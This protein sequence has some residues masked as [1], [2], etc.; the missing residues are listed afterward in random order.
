MKV[1]DFD[2][3]EYDSLVGI[4]YDTTYNGAY[5][6]AETEDG[7]YIYGYSRINCRKGDFVLVSVKNILRNGNV[8]FLVE[9]FSKFIFSNTLFC[10]YLKMN[11]KKGVE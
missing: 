2:V 9:S 1:F 3:T 4:V 7:N 10:E 8:Y 5:I 6:V 11:S